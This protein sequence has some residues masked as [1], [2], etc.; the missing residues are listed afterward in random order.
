MIL[1]FKNF[2]FYELLDPKKKLEIIF[3][4]KYQKIAKEIISYLK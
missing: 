3:D 2:Y 4:N 1:V